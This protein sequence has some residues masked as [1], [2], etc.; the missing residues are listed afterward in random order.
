VESVPGPRRGPS[1]EYDGR[2]V[3]VGGYVMLLLLGVAQ[4]VIGCF[5]YSRALGP[6]PAA[7]LAFDVAI[8]VTCVLG[9]WG[10]RSP[11]GGLMPAVGWFVS[12]FVL[13]MSTSGG[14]VVIAANIGASKW[15]LFGGSACAAAGVLVALAWSS[16][17]RK[18]RP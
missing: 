6:V 15:F 18:P 12:S 13:A 17:A 9:A 3:V 5:Q 8:L 2:L 11:L 10:M 14:S 7:A 16:A 4:S 1:P